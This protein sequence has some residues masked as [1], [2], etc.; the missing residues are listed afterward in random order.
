M[1]EIVPADIQHIP[2]ITAIYAHAVAHGLASFEWDVPSQGEMLRRFEHLKKNQYP[3][4]V[5]FRDGEVYGYSYASAHRPR[6]GYRWTVEN[7]IYIHKDKQGLGLGKLLLA[8]LIE[9][10]TLSGFRQMIAVIGDSENHPSIRLH[11]SLGF[12][13]AGMQIG[14]GYKHGRWLDTVTM[15]RPLGDGNESDPGALALDALKTG[16]GQTD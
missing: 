13:H 8:Q 16:N 1:Y 2:A 4:L 15:Q 6:I 14:V 3:Y 7:A 5:A 11:Q 12:I 9:Q 10:C